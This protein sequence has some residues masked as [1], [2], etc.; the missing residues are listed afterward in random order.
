MLTVIVEACDCVGKSTLIENLHQFI[1]SKFGP[2]LADVEERHFTYPPKALSKEDQI[3]HQ[4]KL[5]TDTV[6]ELTFDANASRKVFL[7]DR[8]MTGELIYGPLY[9]DYTPT[10]IHDLEMMMNI[11]STYYITLCAS[12]ETIKSRFDGEFIKADH[13]GKINDE[14]IKR[15]AD[16]RIKRKKLINVDG[17][18]PSQVFDIAYEFIR[19][20]LTRSM[21]NTIIDN[22]TKDSVSLSKILADGSI[23]ADEAYHLVDSMTETSSRLYV[24]RAKSEIFESIS[25]YSKGTAPGKFLYSGTLT[26]GDGAGKTV[27]N[28][29]CYLSSYN[30]STNEV[31]A[32]PQ[33]MDAFARGEVRISLDN[34]TNITFFA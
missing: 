7:F 26:D 25:G 6:A 31:I 2:N 33:D 18:T 15:H 13:I 19:P 12:V 4:R 22:N 3:E 24:Q 9:R 10:Y 30:A 32:V 23:T 5:Y 29:V 8:F 21:L 17:L 34:I 28:C 11:S 27:R 16:C 20:G 1:T 14:F